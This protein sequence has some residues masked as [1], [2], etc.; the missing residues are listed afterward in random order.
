MNHLFGIRAMHRDIKLSNIFIHFPDMEGKEDNINGD[1]LKSV[2]LEKER[3][4]IK[5]GDLGFSKI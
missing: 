4:L 1:W 3:F 2:N 5:I